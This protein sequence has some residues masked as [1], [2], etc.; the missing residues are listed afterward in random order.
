MKLQ[1]TNDKQASGIQK[2]SPEPS[3]LSTAGAKM[4][5]EQVIDALKAIACK[6][7]G[8]SH[9][10]VAERIIFQIENAQVW[11]MQKEEDACSVRAVVSMREMAPQ[12]LT[13]AMLA[14]QMMATHDAALMFLANATSAGQS[15]EAVDA[16]VLRVT[17]LGRLSIQLAEAMQRLK[18]KASQ[19]N[20]TVG[21]VNINQGGQAIVGSV[22]TPKTEGE[23]A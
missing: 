22:R 15:P 18:G 21:Q 16:N 4:T 10:D 3:D 8:T 13:E 11:P 9:Y 20:L 6:A 17:R 7:T 5:R 2:P 12:N 1:K 14:V 23:A 19:Q